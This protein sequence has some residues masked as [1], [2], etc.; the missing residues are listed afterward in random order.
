MCS[1]YVHV[2][3]VFAIYVIELYIPQGNKAWFKMLLKKL[4]RQA[5]EKGK[6]TVREFRWSSYVEKIGYQAKQQARAGSR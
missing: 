5:Q 2:G 6:N 1:V 4:T 3:N